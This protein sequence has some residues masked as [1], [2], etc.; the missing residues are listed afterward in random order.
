MPDRGISKQEPIPITAIHLHGGVGLEI[1]V[2][3]EVDGHWHTVIMET[4]G[5]DC[6]V[7]HIVE[8]AGMRRCIAREMDDE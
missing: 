8:A 3:I 2:E 7:G 4:H 6:P 5:P 1:F